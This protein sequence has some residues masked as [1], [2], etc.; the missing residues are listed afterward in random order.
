MWRTRRI[1]HDVDDSNCCIL[2][3]SHKMQQLSCVWDIVSF[4]C[5]QLL[6]RLLLSNPKGQLKKMIC[7]IIKSSKLILLP[8]SMGNVVCYNAVQNTIL[9]YKPILSLKYH[10]HNLQ[11]SCRIKS[12]AVWSLLAYYPWG[13]TQVGY[14]SLLYSKKWT[15]NVSQS[16]RLTKS[17]IS[18]VY[19]MISYINHTVMNKTYIVLPFLWDG[20]S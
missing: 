1:L 19:K 16:S 12:L 20:L 18:T 10:N 6:N 14:Q 11:S 5:N 7:P 15:K 9:L 2:K 3:L 17:L 4:L 8:Y 13:R